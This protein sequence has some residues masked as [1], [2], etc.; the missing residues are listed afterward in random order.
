ML[1]LKAFHLR[2]HQAC[3]LRWLQPHEGGNHTESYGQLFVCVLFNDLQQLPCPSVGEQRVHGETTHRIHGDGSFK[4]RH[5]P[6]LG[7]SVAT[8]FD[9]MALAVLL[10][11]F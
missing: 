10:G 5:L 9:E 11:D 1:R 6:Q 8:N 2:F 3:P 4:P 7:M